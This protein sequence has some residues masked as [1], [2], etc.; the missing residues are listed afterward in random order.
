MQRGEEDRSRRRLHPQQR[1]H[2]AAGV[3]RRQMPR[4]LPH[5]GRLPGGCELHEDQQSTI[6]QLPAEADCSKTLSCSGAFVCAS[7]LHCRTACQSTTDCTSEQACMNGICHDACQVSADCPT[8]QSCMKTNNTT[9]CQLPAD[10]DCSKTL[11]L[12]RCVRVRARPPLPNRVSVPHRLHHRASVRRRG[13]RR[14]G[15]SRPKRPA[16]AD[17]P[18]PACGWRHGCAGDRCR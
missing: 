13:L 5:L 18:K 9:L 12:R 17:W 14:P 11:V 16:S 15:R 4:C 2:P 3:Y 10:A 8:G 1:L 6:C 7:D